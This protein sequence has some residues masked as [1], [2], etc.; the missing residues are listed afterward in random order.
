MTD[1]NDLPNSTQP[2]AWGLDSPCPLDGRLVMTLERDAS[3]TS[4]MHVQR[5]S[6][7]DA[8][9]RDAPD[10]M[11]Q[12]QGGNNSSLYNNEVHE[13]TDNLNDM[14]LVNENSIQ[15]NAMDEH[16]IEDAAAHGTGTTTVGDGPRL[17]RTTTTTT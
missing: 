13:T 17:P 4:G 2:D 3:P 5:P 12:S 16:R 15:D 9:C 11:G 7:P 14:F 6:G 8:R 10:V 1:S